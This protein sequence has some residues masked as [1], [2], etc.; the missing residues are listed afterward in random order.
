[1][2]ANALILVMTRVLD[3]T[4]THVH[5]LQDMQVAC[6]KTTNTKLNAQSKKGVTATSTSMSARANR[7]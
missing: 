1:M 3:T 4:R 6:A 7:A 5:A 2:V